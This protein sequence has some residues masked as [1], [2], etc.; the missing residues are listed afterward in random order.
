MVG[1]KYDDGVVIAADTLL[2]YGSLAKYTD[3]DRV[4]KLNDQIVIGIGGDF[5]DFQYMKTLIDSL[6]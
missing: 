4:Y 5:A 1:V 2:S 3:M 6:M